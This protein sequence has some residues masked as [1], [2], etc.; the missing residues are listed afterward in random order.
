MDFEVL[1]RANHRAVPSPG[2]SG[3]DGDGGGLAPYLTLTSPTGHYLAILDIKA[4]SW[5]R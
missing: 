2:G 5:L 4:E 1:P 3:V